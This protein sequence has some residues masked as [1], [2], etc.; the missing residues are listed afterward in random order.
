MKDF[1]KLTDEELRVEVAKA[2]GWTLKP[3]ECEHPRC[4]REPRWH[5]PETLKD[6]TPFQAIFDELPDFPNDLDAC[7]EFEKVL[8]D[9]T[10]RG[11]YAN[12]LFEIRSGRRIKTESLLWQVCNA[13]AR[14]RCCALLM[15]LNKE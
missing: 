14:Q 9:A 10:F 1:S 3:C 8:T 6:G 4:K 11:V 5:K 13:T 15:T 12:R 7:H 2:L